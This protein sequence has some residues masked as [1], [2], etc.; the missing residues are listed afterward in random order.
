MNRLN[1]KRSKRLLAACAAV[2]LSVCVLF[3]ACASSSSG[4]NA[5]DAGY[6]AGAASAA[7]VSKAAEAPGV[8][9]NG[10]KE[11]AQA[12]TAAPE[13]GSGA[14][15][16]EL[17]KQLSAQKIIER[18]SYRIETLEFEKSI[19][20]V[21]SL[22]AELGGYIQE[23]SVDGD[24]ATYQ[25]TLRGAHYVLRIPQENLQKFK[26]G[27][28]EIGSVLNF[29]SSSE[30]VTE[31]YYDIESRLK[32]LRTQEER[33]LELLKKSGTMADIVELEKALADV[34]TQIEQL[35]GS[36]RQYDALI[37]YSTVTVDLNEVAK[38]TQIDKTPVTLGERIAYQFRLSLRSLGN[39][40]EG[41]LVAVIGGLPIILFFAVL[42]V[43]AVLIVRAVRRSM[44]KRGGFQ[45]AQAPEKRQLQDGGRPEKG[46][47]E[48]KR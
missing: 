12:D 18:L 5:R 44:K 21:Q 10:G 39:F 36:L 35:T 29:T 3:A 48:D 41:A 7:A 42:I 20:A 33:L 1:Q 26:D 28:G 16:S 45:P 2:V 23:S 6:F 43:L 8:G 4:T 11:L 37:S 13:E 9:V 19:A 27:A 40:G 38:P 30:N 47:P 31:Q 17:Q 25:N 14:I 15:T 46:A 32:S 34:T 22:C 24:G